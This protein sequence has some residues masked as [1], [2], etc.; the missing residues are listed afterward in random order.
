MRA[1]LEGIEVT[2]DEQK[3]PHHVAPN[4]KLVMALLDAYHEATDRPR[5]CVATGGGTYA[6]VLE[7]GVAFGSV[8]PGEEELAHQA[9]EYMSL[10]SLALNM[11]IFARAIEKLQG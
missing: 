8:F 6:R 2:V 7:E 10:D 9:D 11:R 4:S 5:E 1:A 3:A